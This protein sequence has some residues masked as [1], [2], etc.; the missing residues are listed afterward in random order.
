MP[1]ALCRECG[2]P[3][4]QDISW[5][6]RCLDCWRLSKNAEAFT[7]S[8][9][10]KKTYQQGQTK[11]Q[12]ARPQPRPQPEPQARAR[13]QPQ[14]KPQPQPDTT[15]YQQQISRLRQEVE[16]LRMQLILE[17]NRNRPSAQS[18]S[19]SIPED[20]LGRLIRLAHPDRHGN[21]DASNKATAWL[22]SQR[23]SR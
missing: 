10:P 15:H 22:L 16:T 8:A 3:F 12:Q 14:P 6:V 19:V 4:E 11:T 20:M 5:K 7:N 9:Q 13:P 21:S 17:K 1:E 23:K 18:G 2:N